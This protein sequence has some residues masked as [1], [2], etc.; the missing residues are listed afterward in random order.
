MP[1]SQA[2]RRFVVLHLCPREKGEGSVCAFQ[3]MKRQPIRLKG[4]RR[5]SIV[6]I[7]EYRKVDYEV[8]RDRYDGKM[9]ETF[10]EHPERMD[11]EAL[12]TMIYG[13]VHTDSYAAMELPNE[14]SIKYWD[15]A[16]RDPSFA[17]SL[18]FAED[19]VMNLIL[20]KGHN[21]MLFPNVDSRQG[22]LL[23]L[24]MASTG[25]GRTP[26]TPVCVIDV[27]Q[28]YGFIRHVFPY[29]VMKIKGQTLMH[30]NIDRI[31]LEDGHNGISYL[32]F[33]ISP[34]MKVGY[35]YTE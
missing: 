3:T 28:E 4:G 14:F 24:A 1:D 15:M 29:S 7:M 19:E 26:E 11:I 12:R 6:N 17:R 31:D 27:F 33:D 16:M 18:Q 32:Y 22:L 35:N 30:G 25:D 9:L 21:L 2:F 34:R 20:G 5:K 10:A 23:S 8:L 13:Y